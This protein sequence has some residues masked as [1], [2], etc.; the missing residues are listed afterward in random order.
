MQYVHKLFKYNYDY[1]GH[2]HQF[3]KVIKKKIHPKYM[4]QGYI[5]NTHINGQVM[6]Y[7]FLPHKVWLLWFAS[8]QETY[9]WAGSFELMADS[10]HAPSQQEMSLQS[11]TI[12]HWLG[13]NLESAWD[14]INTSSARD[15]L[16]FILGI[17]KSYY[18]TNSMCIWIHLISM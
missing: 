16:I 5:H 12:S 18:F 13:A 4:P 10:R 11:N 6:R 8:I 9:L 17:Y 1:A 7:N 14:L 2:I 3:V 15:I